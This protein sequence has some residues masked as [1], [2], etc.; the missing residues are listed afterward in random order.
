MEFLEKDMEILKD[1][2]EKKE[3]VIIHG[4]NGFGQRFTTEGKI[5]T[6]DNGKPG[7]Y[8]E[9]IYVEFGATK[10]KPDSKQTRYFAPFCTEI[11][12]IIEYSL[13]ILKIENKKGEVIFENADSEYILEEIGKKAKEKKSKYAN[14]GRWLDEED[15]DVVTE[16]L[17][18]MVGKPVIIN[19]NSGVLISANYACNNGE[20]IAQISKGPGVTCEFVGACSKLETEDFDGKITKLAENDSKETMK[21][22]D[23]RSQK[24]RDHK[25]NY[26]M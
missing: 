8:P 15:L 23:I 6:T 13:H 1:Y 16:K 4:V 25:V 19:G 22:I 3:P 9:V 7:V 18:D 26:E 5:T 14:E 10:D 2:W 20:T 17:Q 21:K 12:P 11:G 24:I